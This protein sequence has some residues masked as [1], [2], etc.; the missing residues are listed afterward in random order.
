[1]EPEARPTS[2]PATDAAGHVAW[3]AFLVALACGFAFGAA[4]QY[5][6]SRGVTLGLWAT[7]A[8]VASAPWILVPFLAGCSQTDPRRAALLGLLVTA[9]AL[10]GYFTLMWSPLE[11]VR[12]DQVLATLP[13]LL[14]SQWHD[15]A[16]GLVTG[17]LF[18][19]VGQRWRVYRSWT[20]AALVAGA[21]CLEPIAR[22]TVGQLPPPA[23]VWIVEIVTGVALAM[24]FL[25]ATLLRSARTAPPS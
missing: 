22:R 1:M 25:A 12:P 2:G 14:S 24:L 17:P 4:D 9:A 11:G 5:L 19:R 7:T 20:S 15:I 3:R 13:Q 18:G 21:F 8:S 16:G 10:A 23:V 6:G